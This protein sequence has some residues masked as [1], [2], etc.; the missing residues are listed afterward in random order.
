MGD[1]VVQNET[2]PNPQNFPITY[3][4][5][6]RINEFFGAPL[7]VDN[8]QLPGVTDAQRHRERQDSKRT[9][10]VRGHV[11][12]WRGMEAQ[13]NHLDIFQESWVTEV[14]MRISVST[15]LSPS[16]QADIT[17]PTGWSLR[18]AATAN[19]DFLWEHR[20]MIGNIDGS[21]WAGTPAIR[22]PWTGTVPVHCKSM[23]TLRPLE[24]L[25]LWVGWHEVRDPNLTQPI[26]TA[27]L[28]FLPRLR[29]YM[30]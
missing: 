22:S 25:V 26:E 21:V 7:T 11:H 27:R 24:N 14:A 1:W 2:W 6:L 13:G 17:P 3:G 30:A 29:T 18:L 9:R 5:D 8:Y 20:F 16:N 10:T 15:G 28:N 4:T 23:R 12:W 19:E